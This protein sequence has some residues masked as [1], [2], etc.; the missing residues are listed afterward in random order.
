MS[1]SSTNQKPKRLSP[2]LYWL[3][4][5]LVY[6][7]IPLILFLCAW[8]IR[9][10]QAW[11][12]TVL[13]MI[14]GIT[15]RAWTERRNPGLLSERVNLDKES[16]I[17]PWDK[18]L[19]PLMSITVSFPL[20]IVAGLDHRFGWSAGFP[21]WANILGLFLIAFGYILA[22][23]ALVVNRFFSSVVRIQTDRRHTVCDKGPYRIIRHPGYTGNALALPGIALALGST[24]TFI[25]AALAL[26]VTIVRTSLEDK[27]LKEELPGY[28]EYSR[29]VRFRLFPGIY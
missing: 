21:L 6:A 26:I 22:C 24:W 17:K 29:R 25:P 11:A 4:V 12:Y 16:G 14:A 2:A 1:A 23:W 28:L 3:G 5:L 13:I 27:T 15:G 18:V 19:S 9:W 20:V 10:W 7:L 8:D